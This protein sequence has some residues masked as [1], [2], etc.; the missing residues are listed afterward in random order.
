M[1]NISIVFDRRRTASKTKNGSVELVISNNGKQKIISTGVRVKKHEW[2]NGMVVGR[3]DAP[4]LNAEIQKKYHEI[5]ALSE[6][7]NFNIKQISI[8]KINVCDW[9]EERIRMRTDIVEHTKKMQLVAL[10]S[11]RDSKIFNSFSDFTPKNLKLWDDFI[12][13]KGTLTKQTAIHNYHKS[14]KTYLNIALQLDLI[15]Q[16]PYTKFSSPKGVSSG[17]RYLTE[18][19]RT[20]IEELE[21][22]GSIA[23]V[24]DMFIFSCYT[25]LA[26]A[27][28]RKITKED[29][30]TEDGQQFIIDKRQKTGT[31]YKLMILPKAQEILERYDYNLNIFTNQKCNQYLKAIQAMAGIKTH[32]TMHVG[33][34]TFATWALKRGV[35]IEIVSKMLAHSD[36]QTTQIYAKVLQ[37]EVTKGFDLLK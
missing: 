1:L 32:L 5:L 14:I 30:I 34:H 13:S 15:Q 18:E 17:I 25:G 22:D 31:R 27:D 8:N 7:E 11:L 12:R 20:K 16:N 37:E 26:D 19:E 28:L 6:N 4:L 10:K 2:K 29:I 23:I 3:F 24:R 36:I 21:L 33:R 35:P 9:I